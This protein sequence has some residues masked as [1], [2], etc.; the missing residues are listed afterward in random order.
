[1]AEGYHIPVMLRECLEGLQVRGEG[2]YVDATFGGGG[3]SRDILKELT[4]GHLYAFDWD[5]DAS[6]EAENID[7]RSFTFFDANFRFISRFLRLS[8]VKQVDGILA[9]L[10]I[11]SHQIDTPERGFSTR[12]EAT[13]DMRMNNQAGI[14]AYDVVNEYTEKEL[15]RIFRVYG[16]I[17]KSSGVAREIVKSRIAEP[18]RTTTDLK[19][20]ISI[21]ARRGKENTFYAKV[22]QAL[23]LEVN[24]EL[25]ALADFLKQCEQLLKPGGRLVVLSY[26][27][28]EDRLVKNL[29]KTGNLEGE[30]EKDMYGNVSNPYKV[31]TRKPL[32]ASEKEIEENK[33]SRSAKLRIAEKRK[34]GE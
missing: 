21:F 19:K 32:T 27:S 23:R 4:S 30:P 1:M 10:G 5:K 6:A 31:I 7:K 18:I 25:N 15:T 8:N 29:M 17:G 28:L 9:D 14:S 2:T 20:A 22:F 26:H 11:S 34:N 13:L 16:E 24:D 3:H 12:F 33:R